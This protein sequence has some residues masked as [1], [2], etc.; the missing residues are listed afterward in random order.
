MLAREMLIKQF[1]YN[2]WANGRVLE[3]AA[4]VNEKE[5]TD[6]SGPENRSLHE[7]LAHMLLV[8]RTWRLLSAHSQIEPEQVMRIEDLPDVASMQAFAA[9]Q[10]EYMLTLLNDWSEEAFSEVEMVRRWDGTR[11]PLVRWHMLQHLL[12]HSMQHRSEAASMLT[13]YGHS[14]GDLDFI[15]YA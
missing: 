10:T 9:E 15:F 6:R 8:E 3:Q 4:L 11:M 12:F 1:E 13:T 7:T 2:L 14:P 5:W